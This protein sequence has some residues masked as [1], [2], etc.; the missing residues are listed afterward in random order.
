MF[1]I[2][3]SMKAVR[4]IT[5]IWIVR[6]RRLKWRR[7]CFRWL[8]MG[9]YCW[10][11]SQQLTSCSNLERLSKKEEYVVCLC[12]IINTHNRYTESYVCTESN[13]HFHLLSGIF[14]WATNENTT[15][16]LIRSCRIQFGR[17]YMRIG[18]SIGIDSN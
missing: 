9:K 6:W 11:V 7:K 16:A 18:V 3:T 12:R 5:F 13:M 14:L 1:D 4:R 10:K 17:H 2:E 15:N 8:C